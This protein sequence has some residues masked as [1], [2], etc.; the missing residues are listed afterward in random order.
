MM[1]GSKGNINSKSFS[2]EQFD[3]HI[4]YEEQRV[5]LANECIFT[6]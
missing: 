1:N 5:C 3:E 2:Q 4:E 6:R